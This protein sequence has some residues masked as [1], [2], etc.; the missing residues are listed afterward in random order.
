MSKDSIKSFVLIGLEDY[1]LFFDDCAYLGVV[2]LLKTVY[3]AEVLSDGFLP[4]GFVYFYL[5]FVAS[6]VELYNE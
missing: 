6:E 2:L 4:V 5:D 1:S 3:F